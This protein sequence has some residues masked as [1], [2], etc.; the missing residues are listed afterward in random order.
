MI[1]LELIFIS[2]VVPYR[3][4]FHNSDSKGW[5][6]VYTVID[7]CFGIDIFVTFNTSYSDTDSMKEI[8]DRKKVA[9]NYLKGWFIIDLLSIVPFDKII[10]LQN[11]TAI[12]KFA[13]IGR[14]Y[15]IIRMTRLAKLLKL[16]KS[17][18]T[19]VS[20][21]STKLKID[22]GMERLVF[23]VVFLVFFFHMS[24]CFFVVIAVSAEG[25]F[26][27]E[28]IE[29]TQAKSW[30]SKF[31]LSQQNQTLYTNDADI[32]LKSLY[33]T[34]TTVATV[35]YGDITPHNIYERMY[36]IAMMCLGVSIF[37]F[38]SGA[39]SSILSN[40]DNQQAQLQEK[41]L[42]LNKLRGQYQINDKLY[43]EIKKALTF[44]FKTN[45]VG[46]DNFI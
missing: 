36:C 38:V 30:L 32:Y 37:T 19:I 26:F 20:Q 14:L 13:R 39:L 12:A 7:V 18:N 9:V 46:L 5:T 27:N 24:S 28:V 25:N 2:L 10:N 23:L 31:V 4:A 42:Y 43:M 45:L 15:K 6:V 44:D 3:L 40:Y 34:V 29:V 33:F 22:H 11:A 21:F 41:L 8:Y 1:L 17:K 16:L 35:G